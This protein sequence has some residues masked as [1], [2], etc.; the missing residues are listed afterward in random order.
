MLDA[1]V[2]ITLKG[3]LGLLEERIH[4]ACARSGRRRE[5]VTLV[6]VTKTVNPEVAALLPELGY[7]DL[8]ESR[9]Q[10]LWRK[11]AAIPEGVCWHLIGHLQRNKIERT[12]PLVNWIHSVDRTSL[13][14][15]L[16]DEAAKRQKPVQALL[17]VNVAR[18]PNKHGYPLE[19][20]SGVAES[21]T[22]FGFVH[23]RGLMTMAP[24]EENQERCR[25]VFAALRTARDRLQ[26]SIPPPHSLEH[27]SM[28]MTNDFEVAIEEGATMIR[29]GTAIFSG[30]PGNEP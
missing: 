9:P 15:A 29:V 11:A 5:E 2:Q 19:D 27:L 20:L 23:I 28:G 14:H 12:L 26:E 13:L 7:R 1:A 21:L 4:K 3:R 18:E 8:G 25:A 16:N 17:E 30:L 22:G 6:C 10:E 24:Y